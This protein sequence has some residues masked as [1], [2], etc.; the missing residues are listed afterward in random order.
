MINNEKEI[1]TFIAYHGED[2]NTDLLMDELK[3]K[4]PENYLVNK[5]VSNKSIFIKLYLKIKKRQH[6][7]NHIHVI[8]V[9]IIYMLEHILM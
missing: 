5:K 1:Q 4:C 8:R 6:I 3:H 2:I 7:K 9:L